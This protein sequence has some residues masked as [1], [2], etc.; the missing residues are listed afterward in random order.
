MPIGRFA[1]SPSA[2]LHVG[3][4]MTALRAWLTARASGSEFRLR[5]DDLTTTPNPHAAEV[6]RRQIADLESLGL[7]WDGPIIHQADRI[8]AYETT[9]D[10]LIKLD[11]A[12]PCFCTRSEIRRE[13]EAAG[14]A[15]HGELADAY[16]GTCAR[17]GRAERA[18]LSTNRDPA[19]RLRAR[20]AVVTIEDSRR[21]KL[22]RQVDDFVIR[23]GDGLAAYNL[24]CVVDDAF[25]TER[26]A[27][28]GE[29]V[30]GQDLL[31]TTPR[32]ALLYDLLGEPR[33]RWTHVPLVVNPTGERLAKRDGAVTLGQLAQNG[34]P[35]ASL[36]G[37]LL[38][39][40]G[41]GQFEQ[42]SDAA[43]AFEPEL[44]SNE[45][46]VFDAHHPPSGPTDG[47]DGHE[48]SGIHR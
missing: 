16:P 42:L 28:I 47:S 31:D 15:P 43:M 34:H 48:Q 27:A 35:P 1:P 36:R 40:L 46:W 19:L 5:I 18:R 29:V 7:D 2:D 30:R 6:S 23:R 24:T 3:N 44:D 11:L 22:E 33:P 13:I 32:Q 10:R 17:L 14:I 38:D 39:A 4:L 26:I 21:G 12:Y 45:A 41:L 37:W 8:D 20:G 9:L 25:H